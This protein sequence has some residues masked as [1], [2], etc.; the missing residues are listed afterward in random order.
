MTEQEFLSQ[1]SPI[2]KAKLTEHNINWAITAFPN[3]STINISLE[4]SKNY[5]TLPDDNFKSPLALMLF[6]G[7][8]AAQENINPDFKKW[9]NEYLYE[10]QQNLKEIKEQINNTEQK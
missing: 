4:G 9:W 2:I 6:I 7:K 1:Q 5:Y 3:S 8:W 10:S